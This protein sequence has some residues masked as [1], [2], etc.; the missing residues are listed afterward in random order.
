M[1]FLNLEIFK[2]LIMDELITNL[3]ICKLKKQ[4][5]QEKKKPK[6]EKY[7]A[8]KSSKLNFSTDDEVVT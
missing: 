3:R 6:K 8:L 2:N 4:Q 5:D 1:P 7:L